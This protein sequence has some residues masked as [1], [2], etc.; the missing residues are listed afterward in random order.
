MRLPMA[1]LL[2]GCVV[3]AFGC[4]DG[5]HG[6]RTIGGA[7]GDAKFRG[8][9][10]VGTVSWT[11]AD[12]LNVRESASASATR[13]DWL[14]EGTQVTI[15]C[16]VQ[17]EMVDGTDVWDKLADP[18]GY[19]LDAYMKT[20][21]A[22]YIPGVPI[23]GEAAGECGDVDYHGY[24]DDDTLVWC[25]DDAL[26]EVDC[27]EAGRACAYEDASVGYNCLAA[28]D[29][30][31]GDS[32]ADIVVAGHVVTG[33]ERAWLAYIGTDV[34]P[35]LAGSRHDRLTTAARVAW[36][37]L[38]EGVLGLDYAFEYSN[39]NF[40]WGDQHIGPVDGCPANRAWQVGLAASQVPWPYIDVE[41]TALAL[42]PGQS[43]GDV[44]WWTAVEA[45]Y[46]PSTT[47]VGSAIVNSTGMLRR[48]WLLRNPAVGFTN[49]VEVVT[50]ECIDQSLSWCFGSGWDTT[51]RYA[52]NRA[53]AMGAIDDLYAAFD[54]LAP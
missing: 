37:S 42:H 36:W 46:D 41:A 17:G 15:V 22:D 12:G 30:G 54:A 27:A 50:A 53:T 51:A 40:E 32:G 3:L 24:C 16:Q 23:C 45:G 28:G 9:T 8:D 13:V 1:R 6:G 44:L 52:P 19:V 35:R 26:H 14:A 47:N 43:L 11:G 39:C 7:D 34:V 29:G 4:D 2:A 48:S 33:Q 49:E 18:D 21:H 10:A 20:G 38:K 5:D 25:E 31:G